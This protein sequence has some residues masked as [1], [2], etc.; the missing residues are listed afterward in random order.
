MRNSA[1]G[2]GKA[3]LYYKYLTETRQLLRN[4]STHMP[5]NA[6]EK[7]SLAKL[8]PQPNIRTELLRP[9]LEEHRDMEIMQML[10]AKM[11]C[12]ALTDPHNKGPAK[13]QNGRPIE[14]KKKNGL[15][16]SVVARARFGS[17]VASSYQAANLHLMLDGETT[18]D[19][20]DRRRHKLHNAQL[21]FGYVTDWKQDMPTTQREMMTWLAYGSLK[22][23][24]LIEYYVTKVM[25]SPDR[26]MMVCEDIPFSAWFWELAFATMNIPAATYHGDL[27]EKQRRKMVADFNDPNS[28][29]RVLICEYGC[30]V[31]GMNFQTC[32]NDVFVNIVRACVIGTDN[33]LREDSAARKMLAMAN[34]SM[35][36]ADYP[37]LAKWASLKIA[38]I[39]AAH[40]DPR[41]EK[42]LAKMNRG[43][44][45]EVDP[46]TSDG[47][48]SVVS[49]FS[50]NY[51]RAKAL[52]QETLQQDTPI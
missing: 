47:Q 2:L 1:Y 42:I 24:A 48:P 27:S 21:M 43:K 16:P 36:S 20:F 23:R 22:L 29:L 39:D 6:T 35:G 15:M 37:M 49:P 40:N 41:A 30:T 51:A 14:D 44:A 38:E 8:V 33:E 5:V 17:I 34:L 31:A 45:P 11:Y 7:L 19:K 46:S 4:P 12:K 52:L 26:K 25:R 10:A 9:A 32:C 18:V 3:G 50:Y 13:V 28:T